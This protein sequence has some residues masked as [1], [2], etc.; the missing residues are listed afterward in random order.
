MSRSRLRDLVA[1]WW[2]AW[3]SG[4]VLNRWSALVS[5]LV[6]AV[7]SLPAVAAPPSEAF[8]RGALIGAGGWLALAVALA[9]VVVVEKLVRRPAVRAVVVLAAVIAAA[10]A[11]PFVNDA[12]STVLWGSVPLGSWSARAVSNT[13]TALALFTLVALI[14]AQHRSTRAA[15]ARLRSASAQL[16]AAIAAG[17]AAEARLRHRLGAVGA[18]LRDSRERML[19]G[20]ID[21][22]AVREYSDLVR[23]ESHRLAHVAG[24]DVPARAAV[25][26]TASQAPA[27]PR[28]P[29]HRRLR[30]TPRISV[31]LLYALACAPLAAAIQ[32]IPAALFIVALAV[33]IDLVAGAVVRA[34]DRSQ[35]P[36]VVFV[37]TWVSVGLAG[38]LFT[39]AITPFVGILA[40]VPLF[41]LPMTAIVVSL[42]RDALSRVRQEEQDATAEVAR[43]A[44]ASARG[45]ARAA[46]RVQR[47][48]ELLHGG[49]QGKCVVF[50]AAV[51]DQPPTEAQIATF[52]AAT[53]AVLD[54]LVA[55]PDAERSTT[56]RVALERVL[57]AWDAV[58]VVTSHIDAAT[59]SALE[60][61]LDAEAIVRIVNEALLNAVKHSAA[62]SATLRIEAETPGLAHVTVASAGV[63]SSLARAGLGSRDDDTR[64]HQEGAD[65]VLEARVPIAA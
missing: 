16:D 50:A 19:A 32:G 29:L 23:A 62:R 21:F 64:I 24:A 48:V 41:A 65:V 56:A 28:T 4:V 57:D 11:R 42:C 52:R 35:R 45:E 54:D 6:A 10:A 40:F 30:P 47:A 60:S 59:V 34:G 55:P 33:P 15:V 37:A 7:F 13:V 3:G 2:D 25:P 22:D 9:P 61:T 20:V 8:V 51:D 43:I 17:R 38:S 26:V 5:L 58:I 63:L 27:A 12:L 53:D 18:S 46:E 39:L 36:A 14:V 49:L 44:A 31:C 1:L